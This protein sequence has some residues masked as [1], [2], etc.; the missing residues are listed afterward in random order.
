MF[1]HQR[2]TARQQPIIIAKLSPSTQTKAYT[3]SQKRPT[4][5]MVQRYHQWADEVGRCSQYC[6]PYSCP[7][8]V[9]TPT[10]SSQGIHNISSN[11]PIDDTLLHRLQQVWALRQRDP[12]CL[13]VR[14]YLRHSADLPRE[15]GAEEALRHL[16]RYGQFEQRPFRYDLSH[17]VCVC[18]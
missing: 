9:P 1:S 5:R 12:R 10:P 2:D 6:F 13:D 7:H 3:M 14:H 17:S 11:R 15:W 4:A 16:A 8:A 18:V